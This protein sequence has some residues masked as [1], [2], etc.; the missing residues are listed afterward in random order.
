LFLIQWL[1]LRIIEFVY[2]ALYWGGDSQTVTLNY[3]IKFKM[4]TGGY[5]D[6]GTAIIHNSG[7]THL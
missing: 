7:T 6:V 5:N 2:A 1:V 3:D 4:P